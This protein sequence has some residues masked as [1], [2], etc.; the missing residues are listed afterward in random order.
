MALSDM[1]L[2]DGPGPKK[3]AGTGLTLYPGGIEKTPTG[4]NNAFVNSGL[5]KQ[6]ILDYVK[7]YKLPIT[8][9][10]DFQQ[11]QYELL[12]STPT[13][14]AAILAM[15]AKYGMPKAGTYADNILG[16]RTLSMMRAT[17]ELPAEPTQ[18]IV[19][20]KVEVIEKQVEKK[21]PYTIYWKDPNSDSPSGT[22]SKGFNTEKEYELELAKIRNTPMGQGFKESQVQGQKKYE[23]GREALF[24]D[25]P[26]KKYTQSS[27]DIEFNKNNYRTHLE[28]IK[29]KYN[30]SNSEINDLVNKLK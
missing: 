8:S 15:Q 21:S 23:S 18:P 3:I 11:A 2:P 28:S 13:G 22:S 6:D 17:P 4:L 5:T 7:K 12:N 25:N 26:Y 19:P 1:Q 14:R 9:N 27:K 29:S 20:N 10:K 30:L 24:I 16:A